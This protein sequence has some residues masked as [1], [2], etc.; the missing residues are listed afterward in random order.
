MTPF[1]SCPIGKRRNDDVTY[2]IIIM[3]LTHIFGHTVYNGRVHNE[4]SAAEEKKEG[5][6]S[7][8]DRYV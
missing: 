4:C 5:L 3:I 8:V 2:T 1:R 6:D 7:I